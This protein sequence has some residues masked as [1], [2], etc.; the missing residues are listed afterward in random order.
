MFRIIL[1]LALASSVWAETICTCEPT[2]CDGSYNGTTLCACPA[3]RVWVLCALLRD[4]G[5]LCERG[6][7]SSC[8][9]FQK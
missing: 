6:L 4:Q 5:K 3:R 9:R 2:I 1:A 8:L 7:T